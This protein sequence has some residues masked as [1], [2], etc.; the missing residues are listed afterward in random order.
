[1]SDKVA[2]L[3]RRAVERS[4][5]RRNAK[6]GETFTQIVECRVCGHPFRTTFHDRVCVYCE[7]GT[8]RPVA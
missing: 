6:P 4:R 7:T 1:V 3:R 8:P 5:E 2:E